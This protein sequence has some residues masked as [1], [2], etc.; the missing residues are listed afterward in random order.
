MVFIYIQ[1]YL[2]V[3]CRKKH[4]S[5]NFLITEWFIKKTLMT[6]IQNKIFE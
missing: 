6:E 2:V 5:I 1:A 4:C 3:L